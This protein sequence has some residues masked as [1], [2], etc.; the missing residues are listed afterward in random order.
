MGFSS[1]SG[2]GKSRNFLF[3][4][5]QNN[6]KEIHKTPIIRL[7]NALLNDGNDDI[8]IKLRIKN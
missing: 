3:K 7:Y 8:A 5:N 1:N 6:P 4:I 2:K